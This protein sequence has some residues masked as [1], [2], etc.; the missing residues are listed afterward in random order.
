VK[1]KNEG[2]EVKVRIKYQAIATYDQ[3]VDMPAGEARRLMKMQK[4]EK[5]G[6]AEQLHEWINTRDPDDMIDGDDID[7]EIE[8]VK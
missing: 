1:R 5:P 7:C 3:I 6:L 8:A 2:E 4:D